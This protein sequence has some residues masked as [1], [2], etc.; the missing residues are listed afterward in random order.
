MTSSHDSFGN[1]PTRDNACIL[2]PTV[3]Y[4]AQLQAIRSLLDQHKKNE[5]RRTTDI[6][7]IDQA[8]THL[9]DEQGRWAPYDRSDMLHASVYAD[10][11]QSMAAIGMLAP[12]I[13]TMFCQAFSS[14]Q[15]YYGDATAHLP[16]HRRWKADVAQRWA[17][18]HYCRCV[19]NVVKGIMQLSGATGLIEFLPTNLEKA[20]SAVFAYRNRMFHLGFEWPAHEREKFSSLIVNE[21]WPTTWFQWAIH[22][23]KPWIC[24]MTD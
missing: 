12:F 17:C 6:L 23:S 16:E 22:D 11:A 4:D 7:K 21:K 18:R 14:A 1:M 8:N 13:E 15:T 19:V 5:N 10:A 20:L 9:S 24:Y 2:L 3:D